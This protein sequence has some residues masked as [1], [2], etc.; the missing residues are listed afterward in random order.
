MDTR[1]DFQRLLEDM[2]KLIQAKR[3][4]LSELDERLESARGQLSE[5]EAQ[6][7]ARETTSIDLGGDNEEVSVEEIGHRLGREESNK[8]LTNYIK[9]KEEIYKQQLN[10]FLEEFSVLE[11]INQEIS[12]ENNLLKQEL[13][14]T[15]SMCDQLNAKS[16]LL[17]EN[18][19]EAYKANFELNLRLARAESESQM[20]Q[21]LLK[22]SH[23]EDEILM[24]AFNDKLES[25][26]KAIEW[27]DE[28][29]K[30]LRLDNQFTLKSLGIKAD[31]IT[32]GDKI[33]TT[34]NNNQIDMYDGHDDS[35]LINSANKQR[36]FEIINAF[37]EKDLQIEFL[38]NQL[39]QATNDLEN[40]A[41][42]LE[43]LTRH[44]QT[45]DN[46]N[47]NSSYAQNDVNQ[48]LFTRN[49]ILENE[50]EVKDKQ[51]HLV[52]SRNY[53]LE[54]IL[55]NMISN[56]IFK[57]TNYNEQQPEMRST[58]KELNF[59]L[60]RVFKE[61]NIARLLL[62]SIDQLR[63]MN[64]VKDAQIAQLVNDLNQM[65]AKFSHSQQKNDFA[66]TLTNEN[67]G[68]DIYQSKCLENLQTLNISK[69]S[70]SINSAQKI[71]PTPTRTTTTTTAT[72]ATALAASTTPTSATISPAGDPNQLKISINN[73]QEKAAEC[74][75][76]KGT[77]EV[78]V[79]V[80]K[81]GIE[82]EGQSI[83][84]KSK[85]YEAA[86]SDESQ[87][88]S[89]KQISI[90]ATIP[91]SQEKKKKE[92]EEEGTTNHQSVNFNDGTSSESERSIR[93][94]VN[95]TSSSVELNT[96]TH[97]NKN[98]SKSKIIVNSERTVN[99]VFNLQTRL[100]QL[101]SENELLE[102]AMKEILLSLKWSDAHCSTILI[103][104]PSLERLCQLIEARFLAKS[105]PHM[106]DTVQQVNTLNDVADFNS[107]QELDA[108]SS[109]V[110]RITHSDMF[111]LIVL[112]SELDLLRGQ[113]EQ[114]RSDIKSQRR[115][116]L[117]LV[118]DS[119]KQR[120]VENS[121]WESNTEREV[122]LSSQTLD[123]DGGKKQRISVECQTESVIA[124]NYISR[125]DE[126]NSERLKC[127]NCSK[128]ANL[129][130]HLL[131]CIIRI[132]TRV[133]MSDEIYMNRL[134]S[135]HKFIQALEK[136]FAKCESSLNES[137]RN[138]YSQ[139]QQKL[140][141]DSRL[142]LLENQIK[143]HLNSCPLIQES[144]NLHHYTET[145]NGRGDLIKSLTI[146][147]NSGI[148]AKL[149]PM[150]NFRITIT[151]LQSIIGC[152]QA[153]LNYKDE[154]L[155]QLESLLSARPDTAE[156]VSNSS[157]SPISKE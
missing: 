91:D 60:D 31:D 148:T 108:T 41:N 86:V 17:S 20:Q 134:T 50:I 85:S 103:D 67:Q 28:E 59:Q 80:N 98:M 79:D 71:T 54:T 9:K 5:K 42:L 35:N 97:S 12:N 6:E 40:N 32:S 96:T 13:N 136:D 95:P 69:S 93:R 132:E 133:C 100:R 52:E 125:D 74:Q 146:G 144:K 70:L 81:E 57:L 27:R 157:H 129:T 46:T 22:K 154:R 26:K 130:N 113:N 119:S 127:P 4:E 82:S 155:H 150:R 2:D 75:E 34:T 106:E 104:C 18:L 109:D 45:A 37:R 153:R 149:N 151:L 117:N 124:T 56:L 143:V 11:S 1:A 25:L 10:K 105:V 87:T 114:L 138:Y 43:R 53:Y 126:S 49:K 116:Y 63:D 83:N 7:L 135:L 14:K 68:S 147:N 120:V 152:L 51:L 131:Q 64:Q 94:A 19:D 90:L 66:Q 139:M 111:Q 110:Q 76:L 78:N 89:P 39:L 65:D 140:L 23:Q 84:V 29:I 58:I 61:L 73:E 15:K 145:K 137:R 47:K 128:W 107:N 123:E 112:K 92:E 30:R 115:D 77:D 99:T 55:P 122:E 121:F 48:D 36:I 38:K 16:H 44:Q 72:T 24:N 101:E 21:T 102:L 142:Q 118:K 33:F 141:A 8:K 3:Q 156:T 62:N 88:D